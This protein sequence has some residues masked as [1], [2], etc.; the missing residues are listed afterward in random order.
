MT[1]ESRVWVPE[2]GS[3]VPG[4]ILQYSVDGDDSK[5]VVET[6]S[7][8]RITAARADILQRETLAPGEGVDQLTT[9]RWVDGYTLA[10]CTLVV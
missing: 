2:Q 6:E 1:T 9:L 10:A 3:H 7:G 4:T 8:Q 5:C